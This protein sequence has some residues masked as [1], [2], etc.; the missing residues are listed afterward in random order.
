V[1]L[2]EARIVVG[3][4]FADETLGRLLRVVRAC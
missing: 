3:D 2:G 4:D 1:V